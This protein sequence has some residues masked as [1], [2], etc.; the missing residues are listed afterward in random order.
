MSPLKV[1]LLDTRSV[2][3][4][5]LCKSMAWVHFRLVYSKYSTVLLYCYC[6][7]ANVGGMAG[8]FLSDNLGVTKHL[9]SKLVMMMT[10]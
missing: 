7:V 5:L 8:E 4:D 3:F 2:L 6:V 1:Y 10:Q 9:R